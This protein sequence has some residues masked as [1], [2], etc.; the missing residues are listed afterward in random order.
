MHRSHNA[1]RTVFSTEYKAGMKLFIDRGRRAPRGATQDIDY[2]LWGP[3]H[4]KNESPQ[5]FMASSQILIM[6][7]FGMEFRGETANRD[8]AGQADIAAGCQRS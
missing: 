8:L 2:S 1:S 5:R 6:S 4:Y 7:F 3:Q